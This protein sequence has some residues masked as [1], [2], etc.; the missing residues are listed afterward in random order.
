[1]KCGIGKVVYMYK[2]LKSSKILLGYILKNQP[3]YALIDEKGM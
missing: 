3:G 2:Y 1:M